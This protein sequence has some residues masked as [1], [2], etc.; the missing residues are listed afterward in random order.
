MIG[1]GAVWQTSEKTFGYTLSGINDIQTDGTKLVRGSL[2][3]RILHLTAEASLFAAR[4]FA[5]GHARR[6]PMLR[7]A[8]LLLLL[9]DVD[10]IVQLQKVVCRTAKAS[11]RS[12]C[13]FTRLFAMRLWFSHASLV[14]G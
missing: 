11:F 3:L 4:P 9:P 12:A 6:L 5:R 14:R 10:I 1:V 7:T 2:L 13:P 8:R